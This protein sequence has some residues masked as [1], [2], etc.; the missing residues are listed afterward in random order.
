MY[1]WVNRVRYRQSIYCSETICLSTARD[2]G[3]RAVIVTVAGRRSFVN[4]LN[5]IQWDLTKQFR[6]FNGFKIKK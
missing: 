5:A 3:V 2:S 4:R 1:F 6:L